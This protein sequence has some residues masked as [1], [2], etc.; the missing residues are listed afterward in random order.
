MCSSKNKTLF[1][2][3]ASF[4]YGNKAE[5]FI[6]TEINYLSAAFDKVIIFP[7]AAESDYIRPVPENV[8]LDNSFICL[9]FTRG[10]K[11]GIVFKWLFSFLSVIISEISDKGFRTVM[12]NLKF[13][14]DIFSRHA[15]KAEK[16]RHILKNK[17]SANTVFYDYWFEN[18]TLALSLLTRKKIIEGFISRGHRF[19]IYDECWAKTGVPYRAFKIKYVKKIYIVSEYGKQ[20]FAEKLKPK[21]LE[22]KIQKEYLG[23][24]KRQCVKAEK[25]P[26]PLIISASSVSNRK[27][28]IH[29]P[30]LIKN[31]KT[32]LRWV[33][34]GDGEEMKE[35]KLRCL[36]LPKNIDWKL[37]GHVDNKYL[38]EF[39]SNNYVDL[40]LSLSESE[41]L[42]VS[43]M[44]AQSFGIPI[45]SFPVYGIPEI[46]KDG[47]TGFC[48][49]HY[50]DTDSNV[51]TLEYALK[52]PFDRPKIIS[53]FEQNF[54]AANN[55]R[56]FVD[57]IS[58]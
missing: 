56:K 47:L 7:S 41:G 11:I 42:P 3:T 27:N 40:F 29:I 58:A 57:E 21:A 14:I 36:S 18:S 25:K 32:E 24:N 38:I 52:Y 9:S 39:Y 53:F 30:D 37:M 2:F 8:E 1:L 28:V 31:I 50:S 22:N 16:L 20:Y 6:E 23:I 34:F 43:M 15:I 44:E 54:D 35:L 46:V 5:T 55:Y 33:H 4:P 51:K 49:K 10:N 45:I 13:F 48:L 26:T 12:Q 19:D 17:N